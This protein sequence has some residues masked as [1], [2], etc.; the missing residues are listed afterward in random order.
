LRLKK[1][2]DVKKLEAKKTRKE[3]KE[4]YVLQQLHQFDQKIKFVQ[5][6]TKWGWS[7]MYSLLK[8]HPLQSWSSMPMGAHPIGIVEHPHRNKKRILSI[9]IA[10]ECSHIIRAFNFF[11]KNTFGKLHPLAHPNKALSPHTILHYC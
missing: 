1:E 6:R 8:R 9:I 5:E 3:K 4:D 10:K 2:Y 7:S 11:C